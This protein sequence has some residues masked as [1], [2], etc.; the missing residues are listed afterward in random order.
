MPTG[1]KDCGNIR[2]PPLSFVIMGLSSVGIAVGEK[3][4]VGYNEGIALGAFEGDDD[5]ST[6]GLLEGSSEGSSE[7]SLEGRLDGLSE[8]S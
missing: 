6:L 1:Y 3:L 8:G 7:G 2:R 5:G 4:M